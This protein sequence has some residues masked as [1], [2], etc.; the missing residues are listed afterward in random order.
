L[1]N[2]QF[3]SN[4]ENAT[5]DTKYRGIQLVENRK[6]WWARINLPK[7]SNPINLGYFNTEEEAREQRN[8]ALEIIENC[9]REDLIE[10]RNKYKRRPR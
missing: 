6:A 8:R 4:R 2:L 5:K 3:I 7:T 10:L 1:I 9:T